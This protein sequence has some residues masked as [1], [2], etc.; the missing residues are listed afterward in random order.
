MGSAS[1]PDS[2]TAS[3]LNPY[4]EQS[5]YWVIPEEAVILQSTFCQRIGAALTGCYNA[6]PAY[7]LT[8]PA[9]FRLAFVINIELV[10]LIYFDETGL[11]FC[12]YAH[13]NMDMYFL[14][15]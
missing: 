4:D 9:S 13:T 8:L 2:F 12:R 14:Y 11:L 3:T 1:K 10:S 7:L 15:S 6:Q 5:G